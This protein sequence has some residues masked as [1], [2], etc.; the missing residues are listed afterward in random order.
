MGNRPG[1]FLPEGFHLHQTAELRGMGRG[2]AVP[3]GTVRIRHDT[4]R[5]YS[6]AGQVFEADADG[7]IVVPAEAAVALGAHGFTA[8]PL[9]APRRGSSDTR[10]PAGG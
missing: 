6:F 5:S 1:D 2:S 3:A 7:E 10:K 4:A 8:A 9:P